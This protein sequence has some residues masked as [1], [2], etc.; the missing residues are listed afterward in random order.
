M[1]NIKSDV[2]KALLILTRERVILTYLADFS[3]KK[4]Y[5]FHFYYKSYKAK[6]VRRYYID[7]IILNF[8]DI[9]QNW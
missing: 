7:K 9:F 5:S 1:G 4:I 6:N 3:L 2:F 8:C